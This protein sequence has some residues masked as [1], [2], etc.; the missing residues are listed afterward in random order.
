MAEKKEND[1][2]GLKK[3]IT[4]LEHQVKDLKEKMKNITIP[5]ED[6]KKIKKILE[7]NIKL[8]L[9]LKDILDELKNL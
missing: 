3:I 5:E 1:C 9:K 2:H 6:K 8:K 7:E 4:S